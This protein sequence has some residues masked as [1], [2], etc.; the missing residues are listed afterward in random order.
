MLQSAINIHPQ[1][2]M[3]KFKKAN[4][5]I[6]L[7]QY[8]V[9]ISASTLYSPQFQAA[10]TELESLKEIAPK[11]SSVYFTMGKIYKKLGQKDKVKHLSYAYEKALYHFNMALDLEAPPK[12]NP[13]IKTAISKLF[14]EPSTC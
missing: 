3:A 11:E 8:Q 7:K 9:T 4:V 2:P 14:A 1:N 13:L 10:L 5:L 6:A 12:D